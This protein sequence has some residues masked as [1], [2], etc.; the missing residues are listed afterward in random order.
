M[1][2]FCFTFLIFL[3]K[4][5]LCLTRFFCLTFHI[6][7]DQTRCGHETNFKL[8]TIHNHLF[9]HHCCIPLCTAITTS[10]TITT[11]ITIHRWCGCGHGYPPPTTIICI[12]P[13]PQDPPCVN[14]PRPLISSPQFSYPPAQ[15]TFPPLAPPPSPRTYLPPSDPPPRLHL[16]LFLFHHHHKTIPLPV[17]K[18][19]KLEKAFFHDLRFKS[20]SSS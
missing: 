13:T 16:Q 3:P 11:F 17:S 14:D 1:G 20:W 2:T 8:W 5:P 6:S 10:F 19:Y 7:L 15:A 4:K 18:V 9:H 12:Q